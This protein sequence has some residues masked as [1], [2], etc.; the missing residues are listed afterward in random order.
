TLDILYYE[1]LNI[2]LPELKGSKTLN[3]TFHDTT[4][5]KVVMHTIRLPKKSIVWDVINDL[6]TK[7]KA[8]HNTTSGV[9]K[10]C[11]NQSNLLVQIAILISHVSVPTAAL[12][13]VKELLG[14]IEGLTVLHTTVGR[15][16]F[17]VECLCNLCSMPLLV[18]Q[19]YH[20]EFEEDLTLV[21]LNRVV[22]LTGRAIP[23]LFGCLLFDRSQ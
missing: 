22:E 15:G 23:E 12:G 1:V 19:R 11:K 7:V 16:Q 13:I 14:D 18:T 8:V 20:M 10:V 3:V 5:N 6:K 4:K 21:D 9:T 2:P 17:K